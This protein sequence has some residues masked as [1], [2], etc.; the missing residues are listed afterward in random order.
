[1]NLLVRFIRQRTPNSAAVL[2]TKLWQAPVH[3]EHGAGMHAGAEA[4]AMLML[5]AGLDNKQPHGT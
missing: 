5:Q 2:L 1:M 3:E 4:E